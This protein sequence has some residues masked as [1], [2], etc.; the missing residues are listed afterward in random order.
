MCC[1]SE[2]DL[3]CCLS[4]SMDSHVGESRNGNGSSTA[5][6]HPSNPLA[7]FLFPVPATLCSAGIEDLVLKGGLLPP[8]VTMIILNWKLT[9]SPSHFGLPM[10]LNQQQRGGSYSVSWGD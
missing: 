6:Y 9:L 7:Q 3:W 5:H 10:L 2:K 1:E 8:G 4:H